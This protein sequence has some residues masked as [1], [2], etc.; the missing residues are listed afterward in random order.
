MT[1]PYFAIIVFRDE[2]V[3]NDAKYEIAYWERFIKIQGFYLRP[4]SFNMTPS[5]IMPV[6]I[7]SNGRYDSI[8]FLRLKQI[9]V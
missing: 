2:V 3:R 6:R 5:E 8:N 4:V 7:G 1:S 9:P